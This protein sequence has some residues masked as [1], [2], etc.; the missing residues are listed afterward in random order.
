NHSMQQANPQ[1]NNAAGCTWKN[2][3]ASKKSARDGFSWTQKER[4]GTYRWARVV[5]H[6]SS[7]IEI[8]GTQ[9]NQSMNTNPEWN[10]FPKRWDNKLRI[11]KSLRF[12][13]WIQ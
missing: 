7:S 5:D 9:N 13:D 11:L 12:R 3:L 6:S 10:S 2:S 4:S 8:E 1:G